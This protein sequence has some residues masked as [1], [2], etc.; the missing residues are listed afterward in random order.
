MANEQYRLKNYLLE[1]YHSHAK[2]RLKRAP[3]NLNFVP[4]LYGLFCYTFTYFVLFG[5]P[6]I[7]LRKLTS[8]T[9][10]EIVTI[11]VVLVDQ[12]YFY[13]HQS[14]KARFFEKIIFEL[15]YH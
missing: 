12:F 10:M 2:M 5:V 4:E 7:E 9:L 11:L 15:H 13:M 14:I 6:D 3:Q 8:N 1:M